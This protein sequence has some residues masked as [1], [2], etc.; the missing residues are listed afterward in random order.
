M[1][2]NGTHRLYCAILE[3]L[4]ICSMRPF[5]SSSVFCS[6]PQRDALCKVQALMLARS[7]L[8]DGPSAATLQHTIRKHFSSPAKV[9]EYSR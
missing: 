4:E 7:K 5:H 3:A 1:V 2:R 8:I 9:F 6:M